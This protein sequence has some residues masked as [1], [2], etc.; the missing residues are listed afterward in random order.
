M[1]D[2]SKLSPAELVELFRSELYDS[3]ECRYAADVIERLMA[4]AVARAAENQL[5]Q[6]GW[7]QC[8]AE[9][10][11]WREAVAEI[12]R[13]ARRH[14][15]DRALSNG[16]QVENNALAADVTRLTAEVNEARAL[17]ERCIRQVNG[18]KGA[19]AC[20]NPPPP[21]SSPA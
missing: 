15:C 4:D 21:A 3:G 16:V 11:H 19:W 14:V 12:D 17:L 10:Q 20:W 2:C 8:S 1:S 7:D 6:D 13:L 18:N 5:L 9:V